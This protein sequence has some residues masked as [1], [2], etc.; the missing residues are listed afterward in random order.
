MFNLNNTH[1]IQIPRSYKE[2]NPT[3]TTTFN[4]GDFIPF[5]NME[6][7]P[8]DKISLSIKSVTN[9]TTPNFATMDTLYQNVAFFYCPN[10]LVWDN[11]DKFYGE[12]KNA[13]YEEYVELF[14]PQMKCPEGGWAEKTIADYLTIPT[15]KNVHDVSALPFRMLAM[16]YN[17]YYRD[18]QRMAKALVSKG[19]TDQQGTNGDNY[20]N[21]LQNGGKV[22]K[23]CRLFDYFTGSKLEFQ[24]G[25]PITIPIGTSAPVIGN[26]KALGLTNGTENAGLITAN[27]GGYQGLKASGSDYNKDLGDATNQNPLE[28]LTR[29]GLS[30]DGEKS[31]AIADLTQAEGITIRDFKQLLMTQQMLQNLEDGGTR[32]IEQLY[33][34]WGVYANEL[35]LEIPK[36]LGS[37]TTILNMQMVAGTGAPSGDYEFG[38]FT[39]M[40]NTYDS[41]HIF[42][43]HFKQHGYLF[44]I[45]TIRPHNTY[46]NGIDKSLVKKSIKDFFMPEMAYFGP[47]QIKNFEI[48]SDKSDGKDENM[49]GVRN[50]GDDLRFIPN[51]VSGQMRTNAKFSQAY[52]TYSINYESRPNN[53]EQF[54]LSSPK[55]VDKTLTKDS[56]EMDQFVFQCCI[57]LKMTR[58]LPQNANADM[59]IRL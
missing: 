18:E 41:G 51:K 55:Q 44:G 25:D 38:S 5:F 59:L 10:R 56:T 15:K 13:D 23:T 54:I 57:N 47:D 4:T 31:G 53:N 35:E 52:K 11:W 14:V 48:Y 8:N 58:N 37:R 20:I 42:T 22:P 19:D 30:Q 12:G 49:F 32:Y 16:I 28:T 34:R 24:A 50:Y 43:Y 29:L 3:R 27:Y 36:F 1:K 40:S 2:L 46:E 45:V 7:I 9:M 33:K 39:G 6:I 21:D 17:E 26:G